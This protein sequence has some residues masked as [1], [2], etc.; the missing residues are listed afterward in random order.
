MTRSKIEELHYKPTHQIEYLKDEII[1]IGKNKINAKRVIHTGER[2]M[3]STYWL[4]QN[5]QIV[6]FA[7]DDYKMY[8]KTPERLAKANYN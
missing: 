4:D 1:Q 3:G 2:I 5:N 6:K 7:M 8:T